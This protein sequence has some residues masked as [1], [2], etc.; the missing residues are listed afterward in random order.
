MPAA[1]LIAPAARRR[2]LDGHDLVVSILRSNG[3]KIESRTVIQ[4]LSYFANLRLRIDGI[5]YR[6]YFTGPFSTGVALALENL[7]SCLFVRETVRAM[8]IEHYTYELADD[9][10]DWADMVEEESPGEHGT[11]M[12]VVDACKK[13]GGLEARPLSCAAKAHFILG[14]GRGRGTPAEIREL[15]R[16]FGWNMTDQEIERGMALLGEL[17]PP[18]AAA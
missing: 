1:C 15:A 2:A 14:A 7:A 5:A 18:R 16:D 9:G 6:D 11:V 13:H 10:R 12:S 3:G 8:P 17:G 4:K